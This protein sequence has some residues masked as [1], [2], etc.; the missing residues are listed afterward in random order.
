MTVAPSELQYSLLLLLS[1]L[2]PP[3]DLLHEVHNK[4]PRI[5]NHL[6]T[7]N[8]TVLVVGNISNVANRIQM[9]YHL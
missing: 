3:H 9:H 8:G 2:V 4:L 7:Y 5:K 6:V 1:Q